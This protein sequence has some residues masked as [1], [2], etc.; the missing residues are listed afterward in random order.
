MQ[1]IYFFNIDQNLQWKN[2]AEG[3]APFYSQKARTKR[4]TTIGEINMNEVIINTS[5]VSITA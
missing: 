4:E 2:R 1:K 5:A 3:A